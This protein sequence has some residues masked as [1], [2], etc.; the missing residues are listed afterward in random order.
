[1]RRSLA[2]AFALAARHY[3]ESAT[4]LVCSNPGI[5]YA[6]LR[7]QTIEA[8]SRAELAFRTFAEHVDSHQCGARPTQI[9]EVHLYEQRQ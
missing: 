2:E 5:D 8:Q 7:D 6:R 9:G 1:M 4:R 3:A